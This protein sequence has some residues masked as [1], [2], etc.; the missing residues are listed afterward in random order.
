[1]LVELELRN[2][3]TISIL[4]VS[5]EVG[6]HLRNPLDGSEDMVRTLVALKVAVLVPR[7]RPENDPWVPTGLIWSLSCTFILSHST[8]SL[9]DF[10]G[11]DPGIVW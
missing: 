7:L 4:Q 6:V 3:A 9:R 8:N 2:D 11:G 10:G 1:M 5:R